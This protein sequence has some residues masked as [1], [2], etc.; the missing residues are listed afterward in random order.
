MLVLSRKADEALEFPEL[1]V[2]IRVVSLKRTKVH[3]GID[4]PQRI[5]VRRAE[6]PERPSESQTNRS[7]QERRFE[8]HR[9]GHELGRLESQIAALAQLADP[10]H[11]ELA[12]QVTAD[13]QVQIDKINRLSVSVV[14]ASQENPTSDLAWAASSKIDAAC[15]RQSS[16]QYKFENAESHGAIAPVYQMIGEKAVW[17]PGLGLNV[18][19]DGA[20]AP[21]RS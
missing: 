5:K 18:D 4:A 3:L 6:V 10:A 17:F 13:A 12:D 20:S 1:G 15:V 7:S 14:P 2:V 21:I 11:R 19:C 9:L 16:A 8:S